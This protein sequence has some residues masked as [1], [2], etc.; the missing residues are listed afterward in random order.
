M[1][2]F[3]RSKVALAA[4]L[5]S[6]ALST[7]ALAQEVSIVPFPVRSYSDENGVDLLSGVFTAYTPGIRVGSDEMGLGYKREVRNL[8]FTDD[9]IGYI[10]NDGP[11][12]TYFIVALGGSSETFT[13]SGGIFTPAE[14]NGSS[15]TFSG[16]FYTYTKSDGK[17]VTFE[18]DRSWIG[19]VY[20][21]HV[22]ELKYPSGRTLNHHYISQSYTDSQGVLQTGRRL[23]SVTTN[24]GYHM[25]LSYASD[26]LTET[27]GGSWNRLNKVKGLSSTDSCTVTAFACPQ[28]GRPELTIPPSTIVGGLS[29]TRTHTYAD[30]EG[31]TTAYNFTGPAL[32]KKLTGIRLPGSAA[33]DIVIAYNGSNVSSVTRQGVTTNYAFAEASNVRTATVTRPG[34]ATRVI[35]FDIAKGVKLTDHDELNRTTSFQYDTNNRVTR[36]TQPEGNYTQLTYDARGN[37]TEQRHVSKTAGSP[38]DIVSTA[39]Y[40]AT[41]AITVKCN[42]PNSATDPRGN[43]TNYTYDATHGGLL[44]VTAPAPTIGATR[45]ETRI[46]YTRLD[47][48]GAPSGTGVFRPTGSSTCQTGSAPTCLGTSGEVKANVAYGQ[49]LL[50]S[51]VS[52]GAG[53][54][55][56]TATSAMT[57]DAAGNLLTVDG[58]LAGTAD[59]AR[60]R[61]NF[62][63]ELV[64]TTSPDPDGTG[65]LKDRAV[66]YSYN[67]RGQIWLTQFGTVTDQSDTAWANFAEAN[68]HF[69]QI[70]GNGRIIRETAWSAGLD[71]A[72]VDHVYD[73]HGRL[74]CSVTYMD[75]AVWGPQAIACQPLQI[76]GPNGPDRVAKAIYDAASQVSQIQAKVG[77][78]DQANEQTLTYT[79]NGQLA[80][81]T[82]AENNKTTYEYD[83]FDRLSKT[84]FPDTTKG[85]GTSSASDYEVLTYDAASNILTKRPRGTASVFTFTYDNLNRMTAKDIPGTSID[86]SYGYDHLGR[87]TSANQTSNNLSFT[88]DAL[89]RN[90]TQTGPRGTISSCW[91]DAGRRTRLVYEGSCANATFWMDY[92]YLVTGDMTKIRENGVTTGI[93]VLATFAYDNLGRRTSLAFGNGTSQTYE[94]DPIGRMSGLKLD[95]DL[96]GTANDLVIGKVGATGTAM[97]YNPASQITSQARFTTAT[98]DPYAWTGAVAVNRPYASNGLNQYTL[99]GTIVPTYD[100]RGNL[101]SAGTTTYGYSFENMLTSATGGTSATLS[102]DPGLRL[103]QVTS[104]ATTTRFGYDGLNL[105]AEYDGSN[106]ILRRYVHGSGMDQPLV[107][108]EG[109][110][111]ATRRFLHADERGSIIA[112]S[113]ASGNAF[114]KNSYDEYGIPQTDGPAGNNLNYGRFQYTGQI[115]L[116]ELGMYHYKA[117]MYSPTL[118][119]FLQT[120]PIGYGDG[121]NMYAYVRN[122]PINL[123][124]PLGLD[125]DDITVTGT[126]CGG[127]WVGSDDSGWTCSS[128]MATLSLM[129]G[130]GAPYSYGPG[131][132]SSSWGHSYKP[133]RP[134]SQPNCNLT[135]EEEAYLVQ[136]FATPFEPGK[137]AVDGQVDLF[138]FNPIEQSITNNGR[139]VINVTLPGH[140]FHSNEGGGRVVRAIIQGSDGTVYSSTQGTGTNYSQFWAGANQLLGPM[141]FAANDI[142]MGEYIAESGICN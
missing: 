89:S 37:V 116:P 54:N 60:Y 119:R 114:A 120:D 55:S 80:T 102:Y 11:T 33:D 111:T 7:P 41:C 67:D 24:A 64:G 103:Y 74:S 21:N 90:L 9:T 56:L 109:A 106:A 29:G 96:A 68:R 95:L 77:T 20:G 130:F 134:V 45:P 100:S 94:F 10:D 107:Q 128:T 93:G 127:V 57:Y 17:V 47:S 27:N 75:P 48:A 86:V 126:R 117:R 15:L 4:I 124:D 104:G 92:D 132:A 133:L 42:S 6:T 138:G 73:S 70:D 22:T 131:G 121:M 81:L 135:T 23:Q 82:D 19:G 36:V 91:D 108:Y 118:G 141:I 35:T 105:I 1:R 26:T 8:Y 122:D 99:S 58:P 101:T 40:D 34:G 76:N 14:Q 125:G 79:N 84:R 59:T 46:S 61:Y 69:R 12:S 112:V 18:G 39:S 87:L 43:V 71:Y 16:T 123:I 139:A 129:R 3:H 31:R 85:A 53:D 62:N 97:A 113:D 65:N 66:R 38:A 25:K 5:A 32:D 44:T 72:V 142:A 88:Y 49:G 50:P 140:F 98:Q 13:Q 28:T 83:G 110:G 136:H 51:S 63:R 2:G 137:Q 78:A 52:Q 30:A 115:W